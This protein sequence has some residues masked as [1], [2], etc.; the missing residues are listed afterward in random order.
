MP[1]PNWV[2]KQTYIQDLSTNM[3]Y[4]KPPT[5]NWNGVALAM[6][7][8]SPGETIGVFGSHQAPSVGVGNANAAE[9]VKWPSG[10]V[11]GLTVMGMD[12]NSELRGGLSLGAAYGGAVHDLEF[13]DFK[14]KANSQAAVIA[15][16]HTGPYTN[17]VFKNIIFDTS[18]LAPDGKPVN[19]WVF[20]L[21]GNSQF[22]IENCHQTHQNGEHFCY[23][24]NAQG[25]SVVKDCTAFRNGRTMIQCQNRVESGP[26]GFG[27]I[28]IDNCV[29]TESGCTERASAFTV[30][31]HLGE[32]TFRGCKTVN[33]FGGGLVN[34][35]E[36]PDP[37]TTP[38]KL[39]AHKNANGFSTSKIKII[40][41]EFE[42]PLSDRDAMAVSMAEVLELDQNKIVQFTHAGLHMNHQTNVLHNGSAKFLSPNPS[43]GVWNCPKKV[44]DGSDKNTWITLTDQQIDAMV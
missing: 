9:T 25:D 5:G 17:L 39:G 32:V 36:P 15:Y 14:W 19:K 20:R 7:M 16:A 2:V 28:L 43:Q 3:K 18:A 40:G 11:H 6:K 27:N 21:H 1:R 23:W 35:Y 42:G 31:G 24:D 44:I 10:P 13:S 30:G 41:C 34:W 8:A 4:L 38:V 37:K 26:S 29:A 33:A 22:Y 12:A